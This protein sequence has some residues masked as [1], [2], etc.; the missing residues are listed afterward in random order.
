MEGEGVMIV[1]HQSALV[2]INQVHLPLSATPPLSDLLFIP[3]WRE[4]AFYKHSNGRLSTQLT[5]C[6]WR[7][8]L[9]DYTH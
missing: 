3:V 6:S 8:S 4:S 5:Y 1:I 7:E 9:Q 2:L